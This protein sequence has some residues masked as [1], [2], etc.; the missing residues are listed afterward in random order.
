MKTIP[1]HR[2]LVSFPLEEIVDALLGGLDFVEIPQAVAE[3]LLIVS[4]NKHVCHV[5]MPS[6]ENL[7]IFSSP[8]LVPRLWSLKHWQF[9]AEKWLRARSL[10]DK[11]RE[12]RF[13]YDANVKIISKAILRLA[14]VTP[15]AATV[16]ARM[17]LDKHDY[18][19]IK[20]LGVKKLIEHSNEI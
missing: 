6:D 7:D 13:V 19:K 15:D 4:K 3:Q 18:N 11:N 2:Q 12:A 16:L 9:S 17:M 1:P 10:S 20:A 5:Q 14:Y 8:I